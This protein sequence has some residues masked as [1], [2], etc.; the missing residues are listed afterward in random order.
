[1]F[2]YVFL[3]LSKEKE[4]EA[5][6]EGGGEKK[7]EGYREGGK[8]R[9]TERERGRKGEK[10]IMHQDAGYKCRI[11]CYKAAPM[12]NNALDSTP[13]FLSHLLPTETFFCLYLQSFLISSGPC[14]HTISTTQHFVSVLCFVAL[15]SCQVH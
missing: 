13:F 5:G 10:G 8:E 11:H 3:F 12:T 7:R 1:M 14:L 4:K 15:L 6:R 9:E 2:H